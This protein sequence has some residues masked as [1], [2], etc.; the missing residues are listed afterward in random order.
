[1]WK[2][3]SSLEQYLPANFSIVLE[4]GFP[5]MSNKGGIPLQ[6]IK[7]ASR[8]IFFIFS[9]RIGRI[10]HCSSPYSL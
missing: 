5:F 7:E 2:E 1:M 9:E 8:V 3:T 6:Q 10:L 4:K